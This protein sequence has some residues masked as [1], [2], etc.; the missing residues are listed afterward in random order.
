MAVP[1]VFQLPKQT[2]FKLGVTVP[3][4]KAQFYAAGTTTAQAVYTT[5]DLDVAHANPVVADSAGEFAAIYLNDDLAYRVQIFDANDVLIYDQDEINDPNVRAPYYARTTA[6]Q[7]AGITPTNY[8]YEDR[9]PYRYDSLA[10]IA[11]DASTALG[12]AK[13]V[14][15]QAG[16]PLLLKGRSYTVLSELDVDGAMSIDCGGSAMID[17]SAATSVGNFPDLAVVYFDGGSL[18]QLADLSV[19]PTKGTNTLTFASAPSL[20]EGD[21]FVIYNP[22]NS[23]FSGFRTNYFAGEFCRVYT[24]SGTSVTIYGGLYAGYTAGDV[25]IYKLA[26]RKFDIANGSLFVKA[27]QSLNTVRGI[28]MVNGV[29][30][31][32]TAAVESSG[33]GDTSINFKRCFDV[34]APAVHARQNETGESGTDYGVSVGNSQ[35]MWIQG[36]FYADRHAVT[37]G[38]GGEVGDVPC[39]NVHVKGVF[40]N[41]ADRDTTCAADHHGNVEFCSYEGLYDGGLNVSGDN[42]TYKGSVIKHAD[43]NGIAIN[44]TEMLGFNF[45]LSGLRIDTSGDPIDIT[46]GTIDIGGNSNDLTSDTVR[47][48][49]LDLSGIVVNAPDAQRIVNIRNRGATG[50]ADPL[51]IDMRGIKV[52]D[53][54]ESGSAI[55]LIDAIF[56]DDFDLLFVGDNYPDDVDDTWSIAN[57]GEVRGMVG[58]LSFGN[59]DATPSVKD[60][61][62]VYLTGTSALTITDFDDG[63][64]GQQITLISKAAITFDTTGTNLTGSSVDLVTASG[65][66]TRWICEDGTTWRLMA[67]VDASVDNSGGA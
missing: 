5:A 64:E 43:G 44:F 63:R 36:T 9:D 65:D 15:I 12:H 57:V 32:W 66:V 11:T 26:G 46:R 51:I 52:I 34:I 31:R 28:R 48:G 56:G 49:V 22:T 13:D 54:D 53:W 35:D 37:L 50:I 59:T 7:T 45:D 60:R 20:G 61:R 24:A 62:K 55:H 40:T 19:S 8:Q 17:A 18:T 23:S 33:S 16:L 67:F 4:A 10:N 2:P 27:P 6:E 30:S 14:A 1:R 41:N 42:N 21:V 29:G 47:G 3:G 58:T 25:D 38:G 39:R